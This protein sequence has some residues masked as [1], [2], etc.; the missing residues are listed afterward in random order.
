[1]EHGAVL[2]VEGMEE[3]HESEGPALRTC[4]PFA[5]IYI[6]TATPNGR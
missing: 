2:Q 6:G 4:H 5:D 3:S 1:M